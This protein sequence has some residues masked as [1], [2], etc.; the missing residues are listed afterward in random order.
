[1]KRIVLGGTILVAFAFAATASLLVPRPSTAS[2]ESKPS[3][4]LAQAPSG[5]GSIAES[6]RMPVPIVRKREPASVP[7]PDASSM[8]ALSGQGAGENPPAVAMSEPPG[9]P[10][11]PPASTSTPAPNPPWTYPG[12]TIPAPAFTPRPNEG[13]YVVIPIDNQRILIVSRDRWG[14]HDEKA[15]KKGKHR[16]RGWD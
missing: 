7:E 9:V 1:M 3:D 13:R 2:P 15:E 8:P 16:R 6:G 10:I 14:D 4:V 12:T 11:E 5:V